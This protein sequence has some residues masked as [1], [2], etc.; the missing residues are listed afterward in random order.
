MRETTEQNTN[1]SI[2]R[3]HK[4]I[5]VTYALPYAN[6]PL[7]LG[8]MVGFIQTDIWVRTQRMLG[9]ECLFVCG[10]DAHGTPIML[11]AEQLGI[12]PEALIDQIHTL[13]SQ[14]LS[15]FRIGLDN[16]YTTHSPENNTLA[17][18]IYTR[19]RDKGDITE[20]TI[21]QSYDATK[22]MFLPDRFIKGTCPRC[23]A[24]EQ[25]GDSCEVCSAT[26]SPTELIDAVSVVTGTR[27]ELRSSKHFFFNLPRY[28]DIIQTWQETAL[29]QSAVQH[30]MNE[31]FETGLRDWD[32]SRDAP[33]FGF[34]IPNEPGKY[35]YVWLD[36]PIGYMASVQNYCNKHTGFSFEDYWGQDSQ[37]ELHQFIG[38]D[39]TYFHALFWPAMLSGS[40]YRLPTKLYTHGFLTVDGQ[41]MS[42][43]RGTFIEA[44]TF[45]DNLE[46]DYLRYYLAAKLSEAVDDI[47]LNFSDFMNRVNADCVGKFVNIAS[48]CAGFIAK[49]FDNT[50][51]STLPENALFT[52][53]ISPAEKIANLYVGREYAHAIREI[54][55]L[56]DTANQYIDSQKPWARIKEE[57][58]EKD[59]HEICTLGVNLFRILMIY[60]KPILV[61]TVERAEAFLNVENQTWADLHTPLLKHKLNEFKPLM[62]RIDETRIATL[63]H[64][65]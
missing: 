5:L 57:G 50:L 15:G 53:F 37:I 54:M 61:N 34:E 10:D 21:E 45:L 14:A 46:P 24:V 58:S 4:K 19:L 55:A 3:T 7:H 29:T 23:K 39:I 41:K 62:T 12:T 48:R 6:G 40:N 1:I 32:I 63:K 25:Y 2:S 38:K 16:F 17:S 30:K 51:S 8:H 44:Q 33:Y 28:R 43:S 56:A 20:R 22:E 31:W 27:P 13:H 26:Y 64:S 35:F 36:A 52:D 59:V 11:K 65:S 49:H 18:G 47:D 42:K 60:L 9:N